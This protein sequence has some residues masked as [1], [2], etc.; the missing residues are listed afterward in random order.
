MSKTTCTR[1]QNLLDLHPSMKHGLHFVRFFFKYLFGKV[2]CK[3]KVK[4]FISSSILSS[5]VMLDIRLNVYKRNQILDMLPDAWPANIKGYRSAI[6][7]A[8]PKCPP[9]ANVSS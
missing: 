6:F 9:N 5:C 2:G 7:G 8:N 1:T 3:M 4:V